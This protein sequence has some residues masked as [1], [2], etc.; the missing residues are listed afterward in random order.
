MKKIKLLI[1]D[2]KKYQV[3]LKQINDFFNGFWTSPTDFE[4]L[5]I[6]KMLPNKDE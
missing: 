6:P 5:E 4:Y 1:S 3:S 2:K